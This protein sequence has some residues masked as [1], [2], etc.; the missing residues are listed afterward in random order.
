[1]KVS[2]QKKNIK[3]GDKVVLVVVE[4]EKGKICFSIKF[5]NLIWNAAK[6]RIFN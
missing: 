4:N 6:W 5:L 2:L 3:N 1:M